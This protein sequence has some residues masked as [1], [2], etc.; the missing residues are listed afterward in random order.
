ME[1][2]F[3]R[4]PFVTKLCAAWHTY[5]GHLWVTHVFVYNHSF[6][7]HCVVQF[8]SFLDYQLDQLKINILTFQISNRQDSFHG[9]LGQW[10]VAPAHTETLA[11]LGFSTVQAFDFLLIRLTCDSWASQGTV[12]VSVNSLSTKLR[13]KREC[14]FHFRQ[15]LI[16]ILNKSCS[17]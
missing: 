17:A 16:S 9:D 15:H 14:P 8:A 4:P 12:T 10:S 11:T 7:Q 5:L 6:D 1:K 2:E 13:Y 3:W